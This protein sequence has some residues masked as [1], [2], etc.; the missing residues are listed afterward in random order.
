MSK[1]GEAVVR[2]K[3][4]DLDEKAKFTIYDNVAEAVKDRGEEVCLSCINRQSS[5]DAKNAVRA[6]YQPHTS[7]KA[8]RTE[9]MKAITPEEWALA[10][11]DTAKLA[12][13]I[14]T[15][16]AQLLE[17]LKTQAVAQVEVAEEVDDDD[18][19]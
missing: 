8:L 3:G 16:S 4:K 12:A 5:T 2:S 10:A 18:D 15:K 7:K 14:E 6:K 19:D 9:A 11:G 17:Q 1:P 13:L